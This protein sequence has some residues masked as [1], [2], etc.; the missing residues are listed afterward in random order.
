ML[1][2]ETQSSRLRRVFLEEFSAMDIA[3]PLVSF[4]ANADVRTVH[5]FMLD[6]NLDLVGIERS[7]V[8]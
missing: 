2:R 4:D 5:D 6:K 7:R 1:L 3:E 8:R